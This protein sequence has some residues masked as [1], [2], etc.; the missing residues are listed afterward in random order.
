[1]T[2]LAG[3]AI[4]ALVVF[5]RHIWYFFQVGREIEEQF[6]LAL[7]PGLVI[8]IVVFLGNFLV[9]RIR[10]AAEQRREA[11]MAS[12]L[13]LGQALSRTSS[14][15]GVRDALRAQLPAAV[16]APEAW[17][18]T[19]ADGQSHVLV[20]GPDRSGAGAAPDIMS[21]TE[22][23]L[24]RDVGAADD[25]QGVTLDGYLCFRLASGDDGGVLGVTQNADDDQERRRRLASVAMVIAMATR[26]VKLLA[27]IEEHGVL[28]GLTG[29]FNRT[30]GMNVLDAELKRAKRARSSFAVVMFDLD[31]FKSVND[32]HGHLCGD[33]LLTAVG[34]RMQELLR[35]SDVKC[36][37]GGEEFLVLLPDTPIDGAVHVADVLRQEIA[38]LSVLWNGQPVS[39][40]ASVGVAVADK[41]ELDAR[42]LVGHADAALYRAKHL[43]RNRVCVDGRDDDS[44]ASSEPA[45]SDSDEAV[46]TCVGIGMAVSVG[47][48]GEERRGG[49]RPAMGGHPLP[50]PERRR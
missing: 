6:G 48:T 46:P 25:T 39:T 22:R 24:A 28:D 50:T 44:P 3:L 4:A 49:G 41:G 36:R 29:C 30:H 17:V 34:K 43:G 18:V 21:I 1:M 11:E 37:Y 47:G 5:Q 23:V 27:D 16:G 13:A 20:G 45:V 2:L 12:T 32:D 8:L 42:A 40:T 14:M 31:Y 33:A 19:R 15:D 9:G 35:N 38:K 26:N 7:V 10:S